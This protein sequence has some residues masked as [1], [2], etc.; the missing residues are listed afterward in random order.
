MSGEN[1][2]AV[3][4]AGIVGVA[5]ARALQKAGRRVMLFDAGE[6]G[7]GTSFGNAGY[8]APDEIFPLT[9]AGTWRRIP[10]MLLDPLGPLTIRWTEMLSL[11]PWFFRFAAA[12][13]PERVRRATEALAGLQKLSV[14]AWRAAVR[15]E[16]LGEL[17]RARGSLR[18]F[19]TR[20]A[21]DA[22]AGEREAQRAFGIKAEALSR[23]ACRQ[24]V[25][26]L[27][28][29]IHGGV[30]FP[31]GMHTPN[32]FKIVE[33]LFNT[34]TAEGGAFVRER[35][36][37]LNGDGTCITTGSQ[38]Y[39]T[40]AVVMA[41]GHRSGALLRPL[42]FRVPLIAERGYHV[43][44]KHPRL[45]FDL[46]L[47][48]YERGFYIT[49]MASGLRLAGTVEFSSAEQDHEPDWRRADLLARHAAALLPGVPGKETGRWMGHR[50]TLPDFLPVIGRAPGS[51]GLYLAFGHQHLGLTLSMATAGLISSLIAAGKTAI[52]LEPFALE[53]F[54]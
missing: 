21:F 1:P 53:R 2:I 44:V 39:T 37:A 17:V 43:E 45:K 16:K 30:F 27:A 29:A 50:P 28:P 31:E 25:P 11:A 51:R 19:E 33:S 5:I 52:G 9:H 6:P 10:G 8:I 32:P 49:P 24:L 54:Q 40:D 26:E 47:G 3:I 41:A 36:L 23:E 13:R 22:T 46:P 20:K 4:G 7:R 35:V 15:E 48:F 12:S 42:G 34:F 18:V 14:P 38:T